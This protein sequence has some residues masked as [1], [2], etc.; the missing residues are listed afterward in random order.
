MSTHK[1]WWPVLQKLVRILTDFQKPGTKQNKTRKTEF[2]SRGG[3]GSTHFAS[4]ERS[5]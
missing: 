5:K 3:K 2:G 1:A 4:S